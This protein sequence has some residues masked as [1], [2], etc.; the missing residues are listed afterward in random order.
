M[1]RIEA[2][3]GVKSASLTRFQPISGGSGVNLNFIVGR[4]NGKEAHPVIAPDVWVNSVGLGYFRTLGIPVIVGREFDRQ[5]SDARTRVVIV[6]QAF[7]QRYFGETPPIGKVITQRGIPMEIVGVV[8]NSKYADIRQGNVPTVYQ[9]IL[10]SPKEEAGFP[11]MAIRTDR[12]PN[13]VAAAVRDEVRTIVGNVP[14]RETTLAEHIDASIVR[15]RLVAAL[16]A[17]F[18]GLALLLAVTGLYGV[19]NNSVTRRTKEIGIRMALGFDRR[20]A[21]S[22]VVREVFV[23]VGGGI[24]LGLPLAVVVSRLIASQ[25]YGLTPDDPSTIFASV[26][27]L[28]LSAVTAAFFPARRA[29]RVDPMVA[30]R[31]E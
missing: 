16:S 5:D 31:A 27:A 19:V 17:A 22:M 1:E 12:D 28:L 6:N 7:A 26:G 30:M 18:G 4:E 25:L 14:V 2:L 21:I 24:I 15:E 29:S 11:Q 23:L 13:S 20:R 10:Q 3:P 9:N 8:G